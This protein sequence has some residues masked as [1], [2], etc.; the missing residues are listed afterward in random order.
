MDG[1]SQ[2]VMASMLLTECQP[3]PVGAAWNLFRTGPN[4][5]TNNLEEALEVALLLFAGDTK[6]GTSRQ[7]RDRLAWVLL[8]RG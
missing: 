2:R 8:A 1:G 5:S 6:L 4:T 7:A 3:V